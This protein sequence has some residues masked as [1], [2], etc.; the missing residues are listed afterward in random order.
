MSTISAGTTA[1]SA[2]NVSSDTTGALV[3]QTNNGTTALTLNT[4]QAVG[5]GSTPSYGTSGQVLTSAGSAAS[6]TWA[7]PITDLATG[8][9][10]TLPVANGGT[11]ATSLTANNVVLGNGT[12]A[13]QFVDP[14]TSG[15]VLTSNGTTWT[16][17]AAPAG[18]LV[19]LSTTAASGSSVT[20]TSG[21]SSTYD[22]YVV[23]C[24]NITLS[25]GA[26]LWIRGRFGGTVLTSNYS[27]ITVSA[28][29]LTANSGVAQ[30][31]TG[32]ASFLSGSFVV[33]ILGA[34]LASRVR[35]VTWNGTG[36]NS[37]LYWISGGGSNT[38][39]AAMNG[40]SFVP[41]GPTFSAGT[42]YLYG[43]KKT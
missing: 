43:V 7:T 42:F 31:V 34:N 22:D 13:V 2:F 35:S 14:S 37:G 33:N 26:I 6:P 25:T 36:Q 29:G 15:N 3:L 27:Y 4:A 1:G 40:I 23:F 17:A 19:L 12:S 18:N 20:I 9:T 10:G 38:S 24:D 30:W 11:G 41:D 32:T 8:V 28:A 21:F 16:S 39:T 5:V